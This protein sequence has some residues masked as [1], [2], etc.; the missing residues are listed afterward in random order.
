ME[1]LLYWAGVSAVA[2]NAQ[3]GAL[4][5]GRKNMGLIGVITGVVGGC[6]KRR[7]RSYSRRHPTPEPIKCRT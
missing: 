3:T 4:D 5:A 1:N 6:R 2:V 7:Q